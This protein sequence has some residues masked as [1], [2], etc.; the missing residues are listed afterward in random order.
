MISRGK[1]SFRSTF[2]F[3]LVTLLYDEKTIDFGS[4]S[5][6][7]VLGDLLNVIYRRVPQVRAPFHALE[8]RKNREWVRLNDV[9]D[10]PRTNKKLKLRLLDLTPAEVNPLVVDVFGPESLLNGSG[11]S[12]SI[13]LDAQDHD[14]D[15]DR[16]SRSSESSTKIAGADEIKSLECPICMERYRDR[17]L[18]CRHVLCSDCSVASSHCPFCRAEIDHRQIIK[19]F[20]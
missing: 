20:L 11:S 10:L 14:S 4:L 8:V 19:I 3:E 16:N 7:T 15:H 17:V 9:T 6:I 2:Q 1:L 13:S 18:P 12:L 5:E